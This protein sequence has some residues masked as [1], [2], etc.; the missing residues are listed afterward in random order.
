[1][2]TA[3]QLTEPNLFQLKALRPGRSIDY[4]TSSIA[5]VPLLDVV[6]DGQTYSLRGDEIQTLE[7]PL[8]RMVTLTLSVV[9]DLEIVTLT[10]VVPAM[11]V[12]A[13]G[14]P[15]RTFA[16]KTTNRTSIGGPA[17]IKGQLQTYKRYTLSG[18]AQN[19]V[20]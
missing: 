5:G 9:P 12:D 2:A 20:F 6:W 11:N 13:N 14:E 7:S 19:V 15:L 16:V 10:F 3:A 8:G 18:R 17:L 4:S 1:M